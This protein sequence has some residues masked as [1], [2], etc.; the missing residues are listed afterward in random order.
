MGGSK[1]NDAQEID[2]SQSARKT[3][4]MK[5]VTGVQPNGAFFQIKR[6][7][8]QKCTI[9]TKLNAY[10]GYVVPILTIASQTWLPNKSNAATLEK[11]RKLANRWI[12]GPENCYYERMKEL[13]LLPLILYME[14]HNI[15]MLL[16]MLNDKC[17]V[18]L[19]ETLQH[20]HACS[21]SREQ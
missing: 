14:M 15:L 9:I 2:I 18:V 20:A 16:A 17:D 10:N 13:K 11:I 5:T 8:S 7:L 3:V 21:N 1:Q 12:V 4:G 19:N 6:I